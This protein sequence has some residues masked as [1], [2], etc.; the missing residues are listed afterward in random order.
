MHLEGNRD[1]G[2][3]LVETRH[4]LIKMSEDSALRAAR[5]AHSGTV[6]DRTLRR[7]TCANQRLRKGDDVGFHVFS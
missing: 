4:L 7:V 5:L 2:A 6:D 1:Q 3:C